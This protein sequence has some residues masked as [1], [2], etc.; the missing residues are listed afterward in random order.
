MRKNKKYLILLLIVAPIAIYFLAKDDKGTLKE[1]ESGFAVSDTSLVTKIFIADKKTNSV[2][3]ERTDNGWILDEK[4]N[5]NP[6]VIEGLLSTMHRIK[7]KSPVPKVGLENVLK[8][9]ASIGIK[10][11]VYQQDYHINLFDKY[12]FFP[13][14]KLS[15]VY[16]IGDITS[17]N[18]G[19]YMLME[20]ADHPYITYIPGFRGFLTPRF[21]PKPDDWKSHKVFRHTLSDI[22]SIAV[23]FGEIPQESFKVDVTNSDGNY[24]LHGLYNNNLIVTFDTLRLLNFLTSFS[25]LRYETRLNNLMTPVEIDSITKTP[26]LYE[27]TLVDEDKD[28]TRLTAYKK[29]TLSQKIKDEAYYQLIPDD[30]DRFYA[31]VNNDEDFVLLQYY[32][33][34]RILYPLSYY[35]N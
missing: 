9:M 29:K 5:T 32:V 19:T 25:D 15:K 12:K 4:Y 2:V 30:R 13:Y 11:E 3:L 22:S 23:E 31:L 16:Y 35:T 18:L 21:S 26:V 14:E 20:D 27:I 1:R 6:R 24:K 10:V 17:D 34:D 7:V 28:T 33:F 8:R